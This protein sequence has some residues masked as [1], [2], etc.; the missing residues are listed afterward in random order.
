MAAVF[1]VVGSGAFDT[2]PSYSGAFI[3]QLW[4]NKLNAKFYA[5]T[6]L[7]EICNTSWEGEIKNQGDT[8][9]I[10][11]AP[12]ITINDYAGAGTTLTNEVPVPI[13]Q[14]M[15]INKGKYFSVQ[16]NDVLA[17]QA[18]MDLMNT[19]TEDAAKQLKIAI[20]NEVFFNQ[21]VTEGAAAANKGA[22]AGAL[23]SGYNLGTDTAPID[24]A[25]PA[26]VLNAILKMSS[27][28][29]EQHVP[30]DGRWL[31]MSPFD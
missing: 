13:T 22:T 18:D 28:L 16:V 27:V 30:E 14:A 25:T 9:N 23:S 15:Q 17:H 19:F 29:D 21:F 12:S 24:Q 10:R 1:P 11:T 20:E 2:N 31:V 7:T 5:N 4:S 6:M 26:N 8:I 3:P